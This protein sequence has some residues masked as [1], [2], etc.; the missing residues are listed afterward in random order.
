MFAAFLLMKIIIFINCPL[1]AMVGSPVAAQGFVVSDQNVK[2]VIEDPRVKVISSLSSVSDYIEEGDMLFFD[3]DGTILTK[4]PKVGEKGQL[5]NEKIMAEA[6]FAH[7][8]YALNRL[9]IHSFVL[10]ARHAERKQATHRLLSDMG[11][12]FTPAQK[13]LRLDDLDHSFFFIEG[14]QFKNGVICANKGGRD[15]DIHYKGAML[16]RFL[17]HVQDKA[18]DQMPKRVMM[19]DNSY[20]AAYSVLK[21]DLGSVEKLILIIKRPKLGGQ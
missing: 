6:H 12:D 14:Q 1:F 7:M 18:P 2:S 9:S 11:L 8:L 15:R 4:G 13:K 5:V 10:T 20:T 16:S 19:I 21:V 17:D 3:V